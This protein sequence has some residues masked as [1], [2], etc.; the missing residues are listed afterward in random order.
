MKEENSTV[1]KEMTYLKESI[2]FHSKKA[3]KARQKVK[4]I[5]RRANGNKL[6]KGTKEFKL[7]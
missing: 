4:D 2:E 6:D 5:D 1:K 7:K 3:D